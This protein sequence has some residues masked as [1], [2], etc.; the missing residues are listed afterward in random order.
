M[1]GNE[2]ARVHPPYDG[3]MHMTLPLDFA[4]EVIEQGWVEAH[5]LVPRGE[6]PPTLF[7]WSLGL[8]TRWSLKLY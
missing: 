6:A 2:F 4:A 1:R 7:G 3:S 8:A 5:P